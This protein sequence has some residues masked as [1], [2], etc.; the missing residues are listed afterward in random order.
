MDS[1]EIATRE[2]RRLRALDDFGADIAYLLSQKLTQ[3]I[4]DATER[5]IP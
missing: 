5:E 2:F 1:N 4:T 3:Y